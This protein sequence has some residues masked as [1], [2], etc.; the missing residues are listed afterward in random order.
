MP[1]AAC[2]YPKA[3]IYGISDARWSAGTAKKANRR[4]QPTSTGTSGSSFH[5]A[6]AHRKNPASGRV[7]QTWAGERW[8]AI[9]FH[10][11]GM[12]WSSTS[13][14]APDRPLVSTGC[15]YTATNKAAYICQQKQKPFPGWK[16]ASST[17]MAATRVRVPYQR[18]W[19]KIR[20]HA[21]SRDHESPSSRLNP[22]RSAKTFTP[23]LGSIRPPHDH[24]QAWRRPTDHRVGHR[25][26]TLDGNLAEGGRKHNPQ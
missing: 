16:S 26:S 9:S 20:M 19:K 25:P 8:G 23:P 7:A 10:E 22:D 11:I 4:S 5:W 12:G 3:R 13:I 6:P 24:Q 21:P 14:E 17:Q 15:V 1:V 2:R 18:T